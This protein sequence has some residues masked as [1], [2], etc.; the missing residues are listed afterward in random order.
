MPSR[1]IFKFPMSPSGIAY[2]GSVTLP[3]RDYSYVIKIQAAE[4]GVTGMRE[5]IVADKLIREKKITIDDNGYEGWVRD[6]YDPLITE[7]IL[8]SLS[9][10]KNTINYSRI[11]L[12]HR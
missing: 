4:V 3:F 11:I 10:P 1:T 7:G 8:M 6:P 9:D 5:T 2:I 12:Y